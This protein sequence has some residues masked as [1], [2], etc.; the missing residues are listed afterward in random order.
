M[1][2]SHIIPHLTIMCHASCDMLLDPCHIY[3]AVAVHLLLPLPRLYFFVIV[4]LFHLSVWNKTAVQFVVL[5]CCCFVFAV[6][7]SPAVFS[8]LFVSLFSLS[9]WNKTNDRYGYAFFLFLCIHRCLFCIFCDCLLVCLVC[10][11]TIKHQH[12]HAHHHSISPTKSG[13]GKIVEKH[14]IIIEYFLK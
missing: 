9:V 7:C 8:G 10:Q 12:Q 2:P 11:F 14:W 6:A 4:S 1:E 3:L 5:S 13:S